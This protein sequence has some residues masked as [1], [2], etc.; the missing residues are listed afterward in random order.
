[1]NECVSALHCDVCDGVVVNVPIHICDKCFCGNV[2]DGDM[3]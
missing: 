2:V 3:K 1:M